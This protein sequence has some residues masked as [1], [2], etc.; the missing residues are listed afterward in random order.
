M[1]ARI[2]VP[3]VPIL[4]GNPKQQAR[5]NVAAFWNG[6]R[7]DFDAAQGELQDARA[8][9]QTHLYDQAQTDA[10]RA[11]QQF[12]TLEQ[13]ARGR[14]EAATPDYERELFDL[15]VAIADYGGTAAGHLMDAAALSQRTPPPEDRIEEHLREFDTHTSEQDRA[16]TELTTRLDA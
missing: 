5:K 3:T 6:N 11:Q 12:G 16:V 14:R 13:R 7:A 9:F 8:L 1:L 15:V 2:A 10:R 4:G